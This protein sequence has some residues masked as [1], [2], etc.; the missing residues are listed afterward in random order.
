MCHDSIAQIAC[1]RPEACIAPFQASGA[2]TRI[3][4]KEEVDD[5]SCASGRLTTTRRL[6]PSS[7]AARG[8]AFGQV[9]ADDPSTPAAELATIALGRPDADDEDSDLLGSVRGTG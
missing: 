4:R 9:A 2:R 3:I 1:E 6:G 8:V 7:L 5:R